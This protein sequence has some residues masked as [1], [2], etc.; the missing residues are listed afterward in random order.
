MA[1]AGGSGLQLL[2][3]VQVD[4]R[5]RMNSGYAEFDRVLGGGIVR[6]SVVLIGGSPGAGKSTLLLQIV[7]SLATSHRVLYITGE[8][9][10]EQI[11]MR[12]RRLALDEAQVHIAAETQIEVICQ[13]AMQCRCELL[14]IDSIQVMCADGVESAPGSVSQVR[15]SAAVLTQFAKRTGVSV[16]MVGHVTKEG[17]IAGP[18]ILE[19]TVDCSIM[20]ESADQRFR[21]LRCQK[22]RFGAVNEIGIFAMTG[23]GLREVANPSAIFL[24]PREAE[25]PGSLATVIWE[26]TRPLLVEL[27]ALV[28]PTAYGTPRRLALGTDHNRLSMLLSVLHRHAG[29]ALGAYDVFTN[30]VGG[31]R[32]EETAADVPLVLAL[33]SSLR[34]QAIDRRT[35]AFGEI[36]LT[37]EIR[38][39]PSGQERIREAFKQGFRRVIVPAANAPGTIQGEGEIVALR[40]VPELAQ[41]VLS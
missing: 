41:L 9:S 24:N 14:I 29:I 21:T 12:S 4:Q 10:L 26:G 17:M 25:A 16:F 39:V 20:L 7:C 38:P 15:E 37:G 30:V 6:G 23:T 33:L 31:V 40:Q 22:N 1:G 28:D 35:I 18:R 19:H 11:A 36:G 3:Q 32:I 8:E 27:Q 13:L 34:E 5:Q 2:Q